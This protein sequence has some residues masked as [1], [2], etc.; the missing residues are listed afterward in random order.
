M[1]TNT[2]YGPLRL[3]KDLDFN[4]ALHPN[5]DDVSKRVDVNAINQSLIVLVNTRMGERPFQ[6]NLGTALGGLLFGLGDPITLMAIKQTITQT[7]QN[8]EP[9]VLLQ[10]VVVN[11]NY[12]LKAVDV[13]IYYTPV[14]IPIVTSF[15]F[16]LE[17]LR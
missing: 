15:T 16:T 13:A 6:P 3:Y 8:Y 14:G 10:D 9:R 7:I 12:S 1:I 4:F 5:T 17:R 2:T 11:I